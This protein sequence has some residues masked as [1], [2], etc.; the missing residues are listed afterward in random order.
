M[1]KLYATLNMRVADAFNDFATSS[2]RVADTRLI[3]YSEVES[4]EWLGPAISF[5]TL[6]SI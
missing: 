2:Y 5:D 1:L 3:G 4:S 6:F